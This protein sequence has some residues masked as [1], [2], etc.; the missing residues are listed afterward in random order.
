[1]SKALLELKSLLLQ[2]TTKHW[3]SIDNGMAI[4]S[5]LQM[6]LKVAEVKRHNQHIMNSSI[7]SQSTIS[8]FNLNDA[9]HSNIGNIE[10]S[11]LT[12][13]LDNFLSDLDSL[14]DESLKRNDVFGEDDDNDKTEEIYLTADENYDVSY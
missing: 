8:E 9:S 4:L 1:M 14:E 3:S 10:E 2:Q 5:T 13:E 6:L 12:E 7:L 11:K